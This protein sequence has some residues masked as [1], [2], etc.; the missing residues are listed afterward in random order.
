M[1][2][3][4]TPDQEVACSSHVGIKSGAFKEFNMFWRC[5]QR[6]FKS[7]ILRA[8]V[9]PATYGFPLDLHLFST[10]HRSTNWA[11]EGQ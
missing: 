10:V 1:V 6:N 7:N 8:G 11:I 5:F 3:R 9:E 4:L 2:A